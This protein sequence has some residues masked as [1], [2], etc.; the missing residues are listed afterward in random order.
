MAADRWSVKH[1]VAHPG[2]KIDMF[3]SISSDADAEDLLRALAGT[4]LGGPLS[5]RLHRHTPR[6]FARFLG[7]VLQRTTEK[8]MVVGARLLGD[9]VALEDAWPGWTGVPQQL[10]F[11]ECFMDAAFLDAL[12]S[13]WLPSMAFRA[14][15]FVECQHVGEL[16]PI[17]DPRGL[18]SVDVLQVIRSAPDFAYYIGVFAK[19]ARIRDLSMDLRGQ[20]FADWLP[21]MHTGDLQALFFENLVFDANSA[22]VLAE[23]VRRARALTKVRFYGDSTAR[24]AF[25]DVVASAI[26][27]RARTRISVAN[28][29]PIS[30]ETFGAMVSQQT[31]LTE[32]K[33][34]NVE[35]IGV[36]V[37]LLVA[38]IQNNP[39]LEDLELLY[40]ST[41]RAYPTVW[42]QPA[43]VHALLQHRR[44]FH[45]MVGTPPANVLAHLENNRQTSNVK[46]ALAANAGDLRLVPVLVTGALRDSVC[47][48]LNGPVAPTAASIEA[49]VARA[50]VAANP[51]ERGVLSKL[52]EIVPL[53][54]AFR[55]ALRAER[56]PST[57][58]VA[59]ATSVIPPAGFPGGVHVFAPRA[60]DRHAFEEM[61]MTTT[62]FFEHNVL[63]SDEP[64]R[65]SMRGASHATPAALRAEIVARHAQVPRAPMRLR[66]QMC[67][68]AVVR[69]P[70]D[71]LSAAE[72]AEICAEFGSDA[73][74]PPNPYTYTL[75]DGGVIPRM[76]AVL[77]ALR[78]TFALPALLA[79]IVN[80]VGRV[81]TDWFHSGVLPAA[82][83]VDVFNHVLELDDDQA[84][85]LAKEAVRILTTF[86]VIFPVD[87]K[88]AVFPKFRGVPPIMYR[89]L[90]YLLSH[91]TVHVLSLN[92]A[93]S[94][95]F[96]V[97]GE[98]MT[99]QLAGHAVVVKESTDAARR[100]AL[101]INLAVDL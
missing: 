59:Y 6:H 45:F 87:R 86:D 89:A 29:A 40:P 57:V 60:K 31:T 21:Y 50:I 99:A 1:P 81:R 25:S 19:S 2:N 16:A 38:V 64:Y 49:H 37:K 90:A 11:H 44:I 70:K 93:G 84:K 39:L 4:S 58:V 28:F 5:L 69:A 68:L 8:V 92:D 3:R 85:A 61:A 14:L 13:R 12:L 94:I 88:R 24:E 18:V 97:D 65:V 33:I 76:P 41:E 74:L 77:E 15:S 48:Q 42:D 66:D 75:P 78:K 54:D 63:V 56:L 52:S 67:L 30:P 9:R 35:Q 26:G 22:N 53:G 17:H 83:I 96:V 7:G 46:N 23:A 47:T 10:T 71:V 34:E 62:S 98:Q 72:V 95:A 43:L 51:D 100:V 80:R 36:F 73:R 91:N 27:A 101:L 32:L 82:A 20:P 55:E 79:R